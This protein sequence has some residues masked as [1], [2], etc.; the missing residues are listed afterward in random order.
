MVSNTIKGKCSCNNNHSDFL[1]CYWRIMASEQ[2]RILP[3]RKAKGTDIC[4]VESSQYIVRSDLACYMKAY[5]LRDVEKQPKV[6][7]LH[8]NCTDG[9]HYLAT[10]HHFYVIRGHECRR[11]KS[12]RKDNDASIFVLHPMCRGGDF[13]LA[14]DERNFYIVFSGR[15]KYL[16]VS[17]MSTAADAKEIALHEDCKGGFYYFATAGYFYLVKPEDEED[18]WRLQYRR[19]RDMK[20]YKEGVTFPIASSVANFLQSARTTEI[21]SHDSEEAWQMD[22][23]G[24]ESDQYVVRSDLKCY[25]KAWHL[26]DI[27][28]Q[29]TIHSLHPSCTGGLHYLATPHYFYV[30]NSNC[31]EYRRVKDL[32]SD[33]DA[34]VSKLHDR[35]RNGSFYLATND[36]NFYIVFASRGKYA[37][38]TDLSTAA[39]WEENDLHDA[40]KGGLHYF[41]TEGYFYFIKPV[42]TDSPWKF[43]Y[44]RTRNLHTNE[45]GITFPIHSSAVGF[46]SMS[47]ESS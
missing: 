44:H 41:A 1:S 24:Q 40:C 13:Y 11:V 34:T 9:D 16:H 46:M 15:G 33:K 10:P 39:D 8:P 36:K 26:R 20:N 29:P 42:E 4:G 17:D 14:R 2:I 3:H 47:I 27:K 43:R 7:S 12:L 45:D 28:W 25:M 35:C 22:V 37:H 5:H 32:S 21:V 23:C 38:V 6:H 31:D 18:R 30:I 19:T